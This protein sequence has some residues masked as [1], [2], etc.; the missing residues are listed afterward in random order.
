M[1]I[2]FF[3]EENNFYLLPSIRFYYEKPN[4]S[5]DYLYMEFVWFKW[6][7]ALILKDYAKR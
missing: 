5:F 4:R 3:R 7:I 6:T 1:K 2:T